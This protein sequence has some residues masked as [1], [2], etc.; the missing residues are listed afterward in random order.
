MLQCFEYDYYST[1]Q[2]KYYLTTCFTLMLIALI[3]TIF[4]HTPTVYVAYLS[5]VLE[6]VLLLVFQKKITTVAYKRV[7]YKKTCIILI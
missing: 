4:C 5:E 3:I 2:I 7:A 6:V 1:E